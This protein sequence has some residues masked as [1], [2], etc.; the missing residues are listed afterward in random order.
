VADEKRQL[1]LDLLARNRMGS[2]TAAGAR[3]IGKIGTAADAAAKSTDK[4][5]KATGAAG[6]GADGLGDEAS[7]AAGKI[8]KLDDEIGK[9]NQ[10][11][12]LLA[13]AL[14]D[15]GS[16]AERLDI[17]KG[18]RQ[19]QA[20]IR[21]LSAGKKILEGILP[22][23]APAA[24]TFVQKLGSAIGDA[25][26]SIA[27]GAGA[28]YGIVI[29]AAI[30]AAASPVIVSA[31]GSA[32]SAGAGAG[33]IGIGLGLAVAKDKGIQD[34]GKSVG[35]RFVEAISTSAV[36]E[37]K[38]PIMSALAVLSEA[39][40][41]V[42]K[43]WDKAFKAVRGS[44]VPL[45][46]DIVTAGE[47]INDSLAG[48]AEKSGPAL[49]GLGGTIILLGDA[50]GDLV[51][52]LADGGPEAAA[53]LQLIAGATGD[54]LK[55]STN[56]LDVLGKLANNPWITGP[57]LPLLRKH[58]QEQ[59]EAARKARDESE[60]LA[61]AYT[62]ADKAARGNRDAIKA[63]SDELRAQT[64]PAFALRQAQDDLAEAQDASAEAIKKHGAN[65]KEAREATRN[66]AEAALDLQGKVG[67]LGSSFDGK[68]TPAMRNT[69]RAAGLTEDQINAVEREFREAKRAGDAYAKTYRA[70]VITE[71]IN[72]YSNIVSSSAQDAYEDTKRGMQKRASGGPASR[73]TPYLVG[74]SGPEVFVPNAAGRVL[75][76]ASSRGMATQGQPLA[77]PGPSTL[78]LELVGP[79][80]ARVWFRK[81]VRTL[82]LIPAAGAIG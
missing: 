5:S 26:G 82:D 68:L 28:K 58:Y 38:G 46:R 36:Q 81:M 3:D 45:T 17:S 42:A 53:N 34:A 14:A 13:G 74:E 64:D 72:K 80:E 25:G 69:Y 7:Q 73:G 47:R 29:G 27:T 12:V 77:V 2:E 75:S 48:A 31:I 10:D 40:D 21:K 35:K 60:H 79:E 44:V 71:Y 70:K 41:R 54:A 78:R 67:A 19:A 6:R 76:A 9:L 11:L 37:F 30:A 33:F 4:L 39:G 62:N 63:L 32:I 16:K 49:D 50:V 20:D 18:I 59:V 43:R 55:I 65:S 66:L 15:A 22:D 52:T 24:R 1:T 51:D 57:L 8:D 61:D 56:F 23:P